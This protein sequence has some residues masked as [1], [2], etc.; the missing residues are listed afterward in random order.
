MSNLRPDQ[1]LQMLEADLTAWIPTCRAE[2]GISPQVKVAQD[3][4]DM[5]GLLVEA[6]KGGR[7]ILVWTG[8]TNTSATAR[9]GNICL[10]KISVA[11]SRPSGLPADPNS[12]MYKDAP[13]TASLMRLVAEVRRRLLTCQFPPEAN[14]SDLLHYKGAETI[15]V[16]TAVLA[17]LR[18]RF[19]L[20][21]AIP[22]PT[23]AY[24]DPA[25]DLRLLTIPTDTLDPT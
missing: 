4:Y 18:M 21:S 12:A 19:E 23:G 7:I 17:A 25:A 1:I 22:G 13:H 16:E 6:P 5:L 9:E 24:D 14:T 15:T 10:Q 20:T 11:V 3:E 2:L 8:D